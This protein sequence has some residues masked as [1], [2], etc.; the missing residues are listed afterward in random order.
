MFQFVSNPQGA[1]V[2]GLS[3]RPPDGFRMIRRATRRP[4]SAEPPVL[5]PTRWLCVLQGTAPA[6]F[7][8]EAQRLSRLRSAVRVE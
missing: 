7:W 2:D 6:L 8:N 5:R 3:G 1:V 4:A